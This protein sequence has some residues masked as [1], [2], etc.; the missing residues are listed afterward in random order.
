MAP[1]ARRAGHGGALLAAAL[2][3]LRAAG[4]P[5]ATL[6]VDAGPDGAAARALYARS[7]FVPASG[8][9]GHAAPPLLRDYYA[10]G[11]HA[12]RLRCALRAEDE[13]Q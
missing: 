3:A 9:E 8:A 7:G 1:S 6:H 10:P 13:P 11:R 12:L 4:V 2:A 5:V